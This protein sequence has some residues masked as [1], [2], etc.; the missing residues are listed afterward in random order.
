MN[1]SQ[2]HIPAEAQ[3]LQALRQ[4]VADLER[5]DERRRCLLEQTSDWVWEVDATG[6]YT[7]VNAK[8]MDLLGYAPEEV[9]GRT[10]FDFMPSDE[11]IRVRALLAPAWEAATPIERL[12]NINRRKDGA[13]V[14]LET[15]GV[16]IFDSAGRFQG[17]RGMDRDITARKVSENELRDALEQVRAEKAKSEA[18]LAAIGDG[19]SI[20]D[21]NHRIIYQ[22]QAQLELTG[23]HVGA[24]CHEAYHCRDAICP[25]CPVAAAFRDGKTHTSEKTLVSAHGPLHIEVT[26]SPLRDS[27][28]R[29]IA[30]IEVFRNITER[31]MV[32]AA[33]QNLNEE[34]DR[35]VRERTTEL[36]AANKELESFS[37]SVS[38]DLRAPL[39]AI[40]G[41]AGMMQKRCANCLDESGSRSLKIISA[42]TVRM[43]RLIDD[44]LSFAR[45]GKQE[46][47]L[48]LLDLT[49]LVRQVFDEIRATC[50]ERQVELRLG[51]LPPTKADPALMR[52]VLVNLLSNAIKFTRPRSHAVVAVEGVSNEREV[53]Y[54]VGDNGVG[55][56]MAYADKLFG[57]FQ[58][59]HSASEFEGTGVGLALVQRIILRHGGRVWAEGREEQGAT[60]YFAL[61]VGR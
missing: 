23:R 5:A 39:R 8:V 28:G 45:L 1:D 10:P 4:R 19:I 31:K 49:Q 12:E 18:I 44:L 2:N 41:F 35:R 47:H 16:P 25:Q 24:S 3:E 54:R 51:E 7:Y 14:T 27:T 56:D 53:I 26:A 34:L 48:S 40:G 32:E 29:I 15:S 30:G 46:M 58:R 9:L 43:G 33:I 11:A 57:V 21:L 50:P 6:T 13:L 22:N 59:L 61:P 60:V 55:F 17:Y 42:E 38:H 37:Y 52:Q 36:E 20:Q